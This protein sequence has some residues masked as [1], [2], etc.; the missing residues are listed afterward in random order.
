M[1]RTR[2]LLPTLLSVLSFPVSLAAA[3]PPE[4]P[5][6]LELFEQRIL[7]IFKSPKP[8]SCVQ[9]HLASVDLKD[10]ILPSQ[11]K[12][13]ASLNAQ[14]LVNLKQPEKSK[15]LK[16]IQMG[17]K[18]SDRGAKLIH[19]KTRQ[20]E[21]AAFS[22]W[23][24]ACC[25]DP[26]LSALPAPA[27]ARAAPQHSNEVI[28]HTRKSRVL[29][30]F[31]RNV[32]SQRMRCFPCHTPHEIDSNNPKHKLP[33]RRMN[34]LIAT[35]GERM[36]IFK[37]S[38]KATLDSLLGGSRNPQE[39]RLPLINLKEPAKSLIVLKPTS[40]LPARN[41][42]GE[43]EPPSYSLPVSH[44]GGLKMHVDD[45]S[46]KSFIAWIEDYAKVLGN[47][48]DKATE[49]PADNWHPTQHVLMIRG[50]PASWPKAARVQL[51][52]HAWNGKKNAWT[53]DPV[54]FTQNT[55]TPRGMVVGALFLIRNSQF[56][57]K[58]TAQEQVATLPPGKYLL[59]AYV[60]KANRLEKEPTAMLGQDDYV[61]QAE[62]QARWGKGF[63]KAERVP[64][65]KFE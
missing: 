57:A 2:F 20:A 21:Y 43:F 37:E 29:D 33:L 23:I 28:R 17:E 65:D 53:D 27:A 42:E 62:I 3:E 7:P 10:Y 14:G 54:A 19:E 25:N 24:T 60:D 61:S 52:V 59:K 36:R 16:L 56:A 18:D 44:M 8:S 5:T 35:Y 6:P 34:D 64:G 4:K 1:A 49:L 46:Y 31:V 22:A 63:P 39:G 30:S 9:C 48:Y 55:V 13:F 12:T 11:E 40:K 51:F 41:A 47:K 38:P 50:V 58:Y 15:I 45:P 32:W 26:K